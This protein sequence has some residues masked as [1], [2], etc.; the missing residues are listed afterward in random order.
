MLPSKKNNGFNALFQH[1]LKV[2]SEGEPDFA[3]R[4]RLEVA[5]ANSYSNQLKQIES[6]INQNSK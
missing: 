2:I 6:L 1:T 3:V 4:N 5:I